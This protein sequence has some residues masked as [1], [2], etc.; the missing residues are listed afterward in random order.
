M[1]I[2]DPTLAFFVDALG[3]KHQPFIPGMIFL[4]IVRRPQAEF[5]GKRPRRQRGCGDGGEN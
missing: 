5:L 2:F 3:E 1:S 4:E